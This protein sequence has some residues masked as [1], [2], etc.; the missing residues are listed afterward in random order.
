MGERKFLSTKPRGNEG[1][2]D[3]IIS[4][5]HI[6]VMLSLAVQQ[7]KYSEEHINE[8]FGIKKEKNKMK[9]LLFKVKYYI[10]QTNN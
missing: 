9:T 3:V 4:H 6:Y 1:D 7:S 5:I 2:Y 10:S 8:N